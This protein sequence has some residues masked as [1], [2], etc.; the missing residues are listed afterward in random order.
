MPKDPAQ[1][2]LVGRS[3]LYMYCWPSVGWCVGIIKEANGDRRFK[4]DGEVVNFYV[5]YEID[6]DTSRHVLK[7]AAYGGEGVDAWVLLEEVAV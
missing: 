7:L 3:V 2:T 5:H 4:M 1:V 6:D